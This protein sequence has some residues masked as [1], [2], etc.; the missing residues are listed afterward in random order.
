MT[1]PLA[2]PSSPAGVHSKLR[3][4]LDSLDEKKLAKLFERFNSKVIMGTP[5]AHKPWLGPCHEWDG[6]HNEKG[7]ARIS[8]GG[9]MRKAHRLAYDLFVGVLPDHMQGDHL[10]D[11]PGCVRPEH[12]DPVLNL[13]NQQRRAVRGKL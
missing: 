8:L 7:Y 10:C 11:N 5:P 12:I 13:E 1:K 9:A 3:T 4:Y 2:L 6:G